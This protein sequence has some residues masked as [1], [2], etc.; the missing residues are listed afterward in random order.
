MREGSGRVGDIPEASIGKRWGQEEGA[1]GFV[2]TELEGHAAGELVPLVIRGDVGGIDPAFHIHL[3][4]G[5]HVQELD[6][7]QGLRV[8]HL[9]QRRAKVQ[10]LRDLASSP[11]TTPHRF[12]RGA[13]SLGLPTGLT[14]NF[15]P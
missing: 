10:D 13:A 3:H 5:G 11:R 12:P 7:H 2:D 4:V 14:W 6:G 8:V 15:L 9:G 1:S